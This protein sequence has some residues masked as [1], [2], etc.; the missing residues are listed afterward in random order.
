MRN[1]SIYAIYDDQDNIMCV[2]TMN[3]CLQYLNISKNWF[4]K[5]LRGYKV[6]K[7]LPYSI[8]KIGTERMETTEWN[9]QR[10]SNIIRENS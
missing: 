4:Y 2:G 6:N 8:Y 5:V 1:R 10:K 9:N 3:E 7:T